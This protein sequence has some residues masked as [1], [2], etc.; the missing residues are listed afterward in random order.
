LKD[1]S[2]GKL[3]LLQLN[4]LIQ[5]RLD[6]IKGRFIGKLLS[7]EF[8]GPKAREVTMGRGWRKEREKGYTP[9]EKRRGNVGG[10]KKQKD[11]NV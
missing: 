10:K 8:T 2:I 6:Y 7:E 3:L 5:A 4:K 1:I 9:G 11:Q